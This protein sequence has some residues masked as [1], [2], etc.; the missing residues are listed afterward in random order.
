MTE[1]ED[2]RKDDTRPWDKKAKHGG[3]FGSG[4]GKGKAKPEDKKRVAL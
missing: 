1:K 3:A 2:R 4:F